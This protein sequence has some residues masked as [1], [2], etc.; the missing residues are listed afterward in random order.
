MATI[1][2]DDDKVREELVARAATLHRALDRVEGRV[3]YGVKM[4]VDP[5]GEAA[6]DGQERRPPSGAEYLARRRRQLA[7]REEASRNAHELG[8]AV[9]TELAALVVAGRRYPPQEQRL[10]GHRGQMVLNGTYLVDAERSDD[11]TKLVDDLADRNR[12]ARLE[13]TGPWPPY[14]F[15]Q[16]DEE[17]S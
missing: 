11:L 15:T 4:Y 6:S 5:P 14:S 17:E 16:I 2:L 8:D 7:E 1:F 3:E 9:H 13:L 10:S 12:D